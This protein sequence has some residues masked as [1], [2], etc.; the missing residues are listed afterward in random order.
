M[1]APTSH[2]PLVVNT[3][4]GACWTRRTVTEGGLALYALA[5]V[6]KCPEFVMVTLAELAERG[7]VGS[8]D[9]LP[10]LV[11]PEPQA[12]VL[13]LKVA[14][15]LNDL[16]TRLAG[17]ANPPRELFL[18]LYDGAEP[19]LFT[20]VE[21][22][23]ECCD[24][25]AGVD[26]HG[27]CWDWLVN[28]F[29]VHVQLWTHPDDDRPM[30]DTSGTVT[31]IVVQGPEPL[32]ELES[33]RARVAELVALLPTEPLPAVMLAEGVQL[34]AAWAVWEQVAGVLGVELPKR[35]PSPEVSADRWTA[36]FAP[37]QALREEPH[38]SPLH[39]DFRL[40]RDLPETGGA[41]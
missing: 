24:D 8:A 5:D 9:A 22:A 35:A 33:L 26:A 1:S 4:D 13:P 11:G 23:R 30:G 19:E 10:M 32:S 39:H 14:V 21:A 38:D 7:I 25:L 37:T 16:R 41:R 29:G 12:E 17:M 36:F 34:R 31:P 28:E 3:K 18:A 40:G 2:D 15:E 6:C 27:K 20:T